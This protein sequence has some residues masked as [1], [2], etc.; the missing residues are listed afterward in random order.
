VYNRHC[1]DKGISDKVQPHI[2]EI[3]ATT[4]R[5]QTFHWER[6]VDGQW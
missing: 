5:Y 3:M 2:W 6:V 4:T 1:T